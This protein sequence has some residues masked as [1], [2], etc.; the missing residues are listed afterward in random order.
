MRKINIKN[1]NKNYNKNIIV[2]NNKI[3]CILRYKLFKTIYSL[4]AGGGLEPPT[5]GL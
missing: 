1:Y 4:V 2:K 3:A 5:F